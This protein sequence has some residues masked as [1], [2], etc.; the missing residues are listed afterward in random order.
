[1]SQAVPKAFQT[2]SPVFLGCTLLG[3]DVGV[4]QILEYYQRVS[5]GSKELKRDTGCA[6][7]GYLSACSYDAD[8][9]IEVSILGYLLVFQIPVHASGYQLPCCAAKEPFPARLPC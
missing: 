9:R 5:T 2:R 1:M 6:K 3:E 4:S 7:Q 8:Y